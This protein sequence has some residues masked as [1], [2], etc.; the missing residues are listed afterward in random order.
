MSATAGT[1]YWGDVAASSES[2][3][4]CLRHRVEQAELWVHEGRLVA[5]RGYARASAGARRE[6]ARVGAIVRLRTQGRYFVHAAGVVDPSGRAFVLTGDSGAGKSTLAYA[7][8][9]A[10]WG[11][12]GDDGVVLDV[13]DDL[14]R[15][16]PWRDPL[17][18]SACLADLFPELRHL[19]LSEP[20]CDARLRDARLRD[21]RRRLRAHVAGAPAAPLAALLF[22]RRATRRLLERL[23]PVQVLAALVRQS[24]WVV[25]GDAPA[26]AHLS[27]LRRLAMMV[28]A[29]RFEHTPDDLFAL[30]EILRTWRLEAQGPAQ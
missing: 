28:P 25:L 5:G 29:L 17:R 22:V 14:V 9:R 11:V 4:L 7:L 2:G 21:A 15:A 16:H 3:S 27:A 12:L 20:E 13:R 24:P 30:P 8:A 18:V 10:G 19:D 6:L 1:W 26:P 23:P